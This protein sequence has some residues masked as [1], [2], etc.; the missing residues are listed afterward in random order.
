[1]INSFLE[2]RN[3]TILKKMQRLKA[4]L[5]F[6]TLSRKI[7]SLYAEPKGIT[8]MEI[9]GLPKFAALS[10]SLIG[11]N[12]LLQFLTGFNVTQTRRETFY[13]NRAIIDDK[14]G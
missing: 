3:K 11:F 4:N 7:H 9:P 14:Y 12:V 8:A 2:Y 13:K 5:G 1:M 6:N 10:I